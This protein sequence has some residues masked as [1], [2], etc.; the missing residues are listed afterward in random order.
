[1]PE[2]IMKL[3]LGEMS[4]IVLASQHASSAKIQEKAYEFQY[5]ELESALKEYLK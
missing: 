2:F 5:P 3:M 4:S 1:V